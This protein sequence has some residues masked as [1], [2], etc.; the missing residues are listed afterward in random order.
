M[1]VQSGNCD[2]QVDTTVYE[3]WYPAVTRETITRR[4]H[5]IRE[6]QITRE[7]HSH[8][9]YIRELPVVDVELLPVRHFMSTDKGEVEIASNEVSEAM[10]P[11]EDW[12]RSQAMSQLLHRDEMETTEQWAV[13]QFES[14]SEVAQHD[15]AS[16]PKDFESTTVHP[17]TVN[18]ES[19][20]AE[21]A[22][23]TRFDTLD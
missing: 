7:V 4:V 15:F 20:A 8:D 22:Y 17:L 16:A 21:Q 23:T 18:R 6:E 19:Y 13:R 12:L 1:G 11:S 3:R 2:A 9:V 10:R 5:E 14:I